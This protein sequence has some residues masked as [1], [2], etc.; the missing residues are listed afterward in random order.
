MIYIVQIDFT[1]INLKNARIVFIVLI[2]LCFNLLFAS[3][4]IPVDSLIHKYKNGDSSEREI[5]LEK[6]IQILLY[7]DTLFS[8]EKLREIITINE[9]SESADNATTTILSLIYFAYKNPLE[10][11]IKYLNKALLLADKYKKT[12]LIGRIKSNLSE[13]YFELRQFDSSMIALLDAKKYIELSN[14]QNEI[15][16]I[17]HK[18]GDFYYYVNLLD[19]AEKNYLKVLQLQ[20]EENSWKY[21][22]YVV[23]NNN[24][25][26]IE[27]K[28][29][30]Y[31]KAEKYYDK[32]LAHLFSYDDGKLNKNDS[33]QI[34]YTYQKLALNE[35]EQSSVLKANKFWEN[36][37]R[38]LGQDDRKD[39]TTDQY[40]IK[41][42]LLLKI[43]KP[44][45]IKYYLDRAHNMIRHFKLDAQK[46]VIYKLFSEY[47]QLLTNHTVAFEWLTL[48]E[49][50]KDSVN[51]EIN[52][53]HFIQLKADS[54]SENFESAIGNLE[55]KLFYTIIITVII[56]LLLTVVII[57]YIRLRAADR[58]LL[59]KNIQIV[60]MDKG[61]KY[62][63]KN[64]DALIED[65][66]SKEPLKNQN[67][68]KDL[69]VL[70]LIEKIDELMDKEKIFL[71][72]NLTLD[73]LAQRI[74]ANRTYISNAIRQYYQTNFSGYI[75]ELRIKES[76]R[77][78]SKNKTAVYTLEG[79]AN[80]VGF[81]NR[82][83]FIAAFKKYTGVLPSS[84]IKNA[85]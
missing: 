82:T 8:R 27:F 43:E 37:A 74:G 15:V 22:R 24:L 45:S 58:K 35:L 9:Q 52:R 23:I 60:K 6:I 10:I 48:S 83:S 26:N 25:G 79:I 61:E 16:D 33:L 56:C 42:Q 4:S 54:E 47:Y 2:S 49:N 28:R 18:L 77:I 12:L 62:P 44:D 71:N 72:S 63:L 46:G 32:S 59:E 19:D 30:N 21:W 66:E 69:L 67:D 57:I 1:S 14:D 34:T 65:T 80:Q 84:F 85:N 50:F 73:M 81:N 53:T 51:S 78:I 70:T 75:N 38:Y 40:L 68:K 64:H 36:A 3:Q 7:S 5:Y 11:K 41:A 17:T 13:V 29:K 55:N 31:S 76:I 39:I 20:G